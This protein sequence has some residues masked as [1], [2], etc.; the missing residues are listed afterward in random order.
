MTGTRTTDGFSGLVADGSAAFKDANASGWAAFSGSVC[1][2]VA[3]RGANPNGAGVRKEVANGDALKGVARGGGVS[4]AGANVV[5]GFGVGT[6]ATGDMTG[7]EVI[8]VG[9]GA[10]TGVG[11][12]VGTGT[13][14][15][16]TFGRSIF[17][18]G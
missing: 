15:G 1:V 6:F 4:F 8:I 2:W 11:V 5:C 16:V 3:G 13:G 10:G 7:N 9:A 18:G 17:A 14:A 12:G